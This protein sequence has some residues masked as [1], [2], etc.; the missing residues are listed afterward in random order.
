M[1]LLATTAPPGLRLVWLHPPASAGSSTKEMVEHDVEYNLRQLGGIRMT[2]WSEA[3]G[4][5]P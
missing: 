3:D 5:R 1:L 2:L 4:R